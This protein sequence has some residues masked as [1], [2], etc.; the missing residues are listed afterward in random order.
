M[1]KHFKQLSSAQALD[2]TWLG[3]LIIDIPTPSQL[4]GFHKSTENSTDFNKNASIVSTTS[5]DIIPLL[6]KP[7]PVK[8]LLM[9]DELKYPKG[10]SFCFEGYKGTDDYEKLKN[11][12]IDCAARNDGTQLKI[13]IHDEHDK[14][15]NS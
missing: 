13:G 3:K 14:N 2:S 12:I 7:S 9:T 11:H 6:T 15:P 5:T 10:C 1:D 4:Q 8:Q